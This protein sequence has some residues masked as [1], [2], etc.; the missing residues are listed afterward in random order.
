MFLQECTS[1]LTRLDIEQNLTN[2]LRYIVYHF[3]GPLNEFDISDKEMTSALPT[4]PGRT[5]TPRDARR[6]RGTHG[7]AER[8]TETPRGTRRRREAHGPKKAKLLAVA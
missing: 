8:H 4:C 7:D 5:E 6:R 3:P 2:I 1:D